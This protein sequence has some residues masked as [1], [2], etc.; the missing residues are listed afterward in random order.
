M[1]IRSYEIVR[2]NIGEALL[3]DEGLLLNDPSNIMDE[4]RAEFRGIG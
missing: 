1:D 2:T 3:G 4:R